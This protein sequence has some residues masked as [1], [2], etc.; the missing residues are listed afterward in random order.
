MVVYSFGDR[1]GSTYIGSPGFVIDHYDMNHKNNSVENLEQI[2][3]VRNLWR[4]WYITK[5][6][7]CKRRYEA[8]RKLLGPLEL[9]DFLVEKAEDIRRFNELRK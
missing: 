1:L 4:A 9:E 3:V 6:D 5:S 8:E 7:N 2:T